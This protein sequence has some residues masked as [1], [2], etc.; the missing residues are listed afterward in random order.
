M[1]TQRYPT[2][3]QTIEKKFKVLIYELFETAKINRQ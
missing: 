3:Y 1:I 2:M